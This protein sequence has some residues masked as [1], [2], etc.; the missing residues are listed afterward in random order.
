MLQLLTKYLLI[1]KRVSIP[2]VGS[3]VIEK[4]PAQLALSNQFLHPPVYSIYYSKEVFVEDPQISFIT[5]SSLIDE[6]TAHLELEQFGQKWKA[7]IENEPFALNG[8]GI[9]EYMADEIIFHPQT[10]ETFLQPVPANKIV[11]ESIQNNVSIDDRDVQSPAIGGNFTKPVKQKFTPVGIAWILLLVTVV[12]IIYH[13]YKNSSTENSTGSS[14]SVKT[15]PASA[16]Y[17]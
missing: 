6:R 11:P 5:S 1:N 9:L 13:F 14:L 16:T 17:R 8:F 10:I 15:K 4:Q 12:S 2:H 7:T 3:F